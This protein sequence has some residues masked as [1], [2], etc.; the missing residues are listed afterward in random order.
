MFGPVLVGQKVTLRPPDETDAQRFIDWF[1]DLEVTRYLGTTFPLHLDAEKETLKKL[2]ESKTDVF[3]VIE[4]EGKAIGAIGIHQI[5][6][7]DAHGITGIVIGDK[8]CWRKGYA[9]E[10]MALRTEYAFRQLNLHKLSTFT[11]LENEGSKRALM[12]SGYRQIGTQ[13]E[14]FWRDGAWHDT[15]MAELLRSDWEKQHTG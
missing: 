11:F 12:K 4:A 1:A 3:W 10:A 15:W 5:A 8:S 9:S 13:K 14:H 6:W 7:I 2:G